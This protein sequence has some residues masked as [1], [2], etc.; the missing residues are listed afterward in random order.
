MNDSVQQ[1]G[2]YSCEEHSEVTDGCVSC[3]VWRDFRRAAAEIER[4]ERENAECVLSFDLYDDA[5]RRG[6]Q[7]WRAEKPNDEKRQRT[8]PDASALAVWLLTTLGDIEAQRDA[9]RDALREILEP[10]CGRMVCRRIAIF[11]RARALL[12]DTDG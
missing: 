3:E 4:L 1:L 10:H 2:R 12:E 6:T 11:D 9:L 7:R 8:L 5:M